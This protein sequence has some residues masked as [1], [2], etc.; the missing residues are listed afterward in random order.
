M[1]LLLVYKFFIEG[2]LG[3]ANVF[4]SNISSNSSARWVIPDARAVTD[5]DEHHQ[6]LKN[7]ISKEKGIE[8]TTSIISLKQVK[9]EFVQLQSSR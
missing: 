4:F 2:F 1:V 7:V 9:T 3:E 6:L 5:Q 8:N